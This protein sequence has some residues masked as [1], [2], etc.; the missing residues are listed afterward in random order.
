MAH[1]ETL[2]PHAAAYLTSAEVAALLRMSRAAFQMACSRGNGPPAIRIGKR[3]LRWR[4][5]DVER[6]L[7]ARVERAGGAS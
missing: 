5:A 7:D 1:S 2:A 3:V 4:R 6:W